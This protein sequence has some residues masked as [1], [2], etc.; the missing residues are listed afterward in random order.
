M[1]KFT[2]MGGFHGMRN[3]KSAQPL[4]RQDGFVTKG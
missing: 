2:D 3:K 4:E 1:L